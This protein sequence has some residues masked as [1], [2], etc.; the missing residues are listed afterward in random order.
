MQNRLIYHLLLCISGFPFMKL[1]I[2]FVENIPIKPKYRKIA[3][4][5]ILLLD[6]D[7]WWNIRQNFNVHNFSESISE[8]CIRLSYEPHVTLKMFCYYVSMYLIGLYI[9]ALYIFLWC[10]E[11]NHTKPFLKIANAMCFIMLTSETFVWFNFSIFKLIDQSKY[12]C[13]NIIYSPFQICAI[14]IWYLSNSFAVCKAK[15]LNVS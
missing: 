11:S 1:Q 8:T 14:G 13:L 5:I 4:K 15:V 12:L 7:W 2:G 9:L 3:H 10:S 6:S